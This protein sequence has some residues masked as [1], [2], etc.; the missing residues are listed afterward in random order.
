MG[1][2]LATAAAA[3][4]ALLGVAALSA[5]AMAANVFDIE[6]PLSIDGSGSNYIDPIG[7]TNGFSIQPNNVYYVNFTVPSFDALLNI[8]TYIVHYFPAIY[9][10][11]SDYSADTFNLFNGTAS[12][13]APGPG[14]VGGVQGV[15]S[16]L[17]PSQ[18][19]TAINDKVYNLSTS[20]SA[21][22]FV[23]EVI[24]SSTLNCSASPNGC[25][26]QGNIQLGVPGVP[27]PT[28]WAMMILGVGLIGLAARRRRDAGAFALA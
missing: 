18:V 8:S 19:I 9:G 16:L 28:T 11:A 5:P 2:R 23:L 13:C 12:S 10:S 26:L 24:P 20:P 22:D 3:A 15:G 21:K 1:I 7:G 14:C 27:E 6:Q 4:T 17:A 25:S